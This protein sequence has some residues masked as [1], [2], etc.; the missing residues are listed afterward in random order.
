M[1]NFLLNR[2]DSSLYYE[3]KVLNLRAHWWSSLS[4]IN[5]N[6]EDEHLRPSHCIFVQNISI[7]IVIENLRSKNKTTLADKQ[8][9]HKHLQVPKVWRIINHWKKDKKLIPPTITWSN[10][11]DSIEIEDGRHRF[12]TAM[13]LGESSIPVLVPKD[14]LEKILRILKINNELLT[15]K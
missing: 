10:L 4:E 11:Y 3:S 8:L 15:N 6:Q 9:F 14:N 1:D 5:L 13:C 2:Y 7:N 12:N